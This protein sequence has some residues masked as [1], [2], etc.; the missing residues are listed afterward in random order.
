MICLNNLRL[1]SFIVCFVVFYVVFLLLDLFFL[2]FEYFRFVVGYFLNL[3]KMVVN[4]VLFLF[5][6]NIYFCIVNKFIDKYI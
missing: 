1:N 3:F 6:E 2:F 4:L 5:F